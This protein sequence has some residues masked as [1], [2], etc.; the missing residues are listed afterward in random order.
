MAQHCVFPTNGMIGTNA[1]EVSQKGCYIVQRLDIY[2][3][4]GYNIECT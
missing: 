4:V 2:S 1:R 3:F